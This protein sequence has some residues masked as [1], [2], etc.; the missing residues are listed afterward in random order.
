VGRARPAC[1]LEVQPKHGPQW[2]RA[3]PGPLQKLRAVGRP[4]R[5]G[6]KV[7]LYGR[8]TGRGL[9]QDERD[10]GEDKTSLT[11]LCGK[12]SNC[13]CNQP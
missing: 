5:P 12:N 4:I 8:R 10:Y 3:V 2:G 6:P 11:G 13:N 7:Q 9:I 1:G